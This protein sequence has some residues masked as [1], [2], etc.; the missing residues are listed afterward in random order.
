LEHGAAQP[1]HPVSGSRDRN[2]RQ[3]IPAQAREST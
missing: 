3:I 2:R 1:A